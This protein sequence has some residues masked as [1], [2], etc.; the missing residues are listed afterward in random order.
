MCRRQ[1]ARGSGKTANTR[2]PKAAA[3]RK[4]A[5]KA[6]RQHDKQTKSS[7]ARAHIEI[8]IAPRRAAPRRATPRRAAHAALRDETRGMCVCD[9]NQS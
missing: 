1:H 6:R 3:V 4:L 8:G 9:S 2:A 5:S 7:A